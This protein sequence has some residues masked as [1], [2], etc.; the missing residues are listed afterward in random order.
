[1]IRHIIFKAVGLCNLAC[2]FC[3]YM[4]NLESDWERKFDPNR[5]DDFFAS[6]RRY[7][8]KLRVSWHGGEP[9]LAGLDFF[10]NAVDS[11]ARHGVEMRSSIQTNGV[12]MDEQWAEFFKRN[13][14]NVGVSIDGPALV[15][16][17]MRPAKSAALG[18]S[19]EGA[20]RAL[21]LL[22][23]H[24]VRHGTLT[25]IHPSLDGA[26]VFRHLVDDLGVRDMDFLLP[27]VGEAQP[28]DTVAGCR[29]YLLGVL[30]AWLA[31]DDSAIVVRYF[32][33]ILRALVGGEAKQCILNNDCSHFITV[34]P[35]GDVGLC[36]NIRVSDMALYQTGLNVHRN[37]FDEIE[38]TLRSRL[39]QCGFNDLGEICR[40]CDFVRVCQGG[41]PVGRYDGA[42]GFGRPGVY[43]DVYQS[44]IT[45][46][47]DY[48]VEQID[49]APL[50]AEAHPIARVS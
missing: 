30:G 5:L 15:Q 26:E 19:Y 31:R 7:H 22:Q 4:E 14:F 10:Q 12:L 18:T 42:G 46:I 20:V 32:T 36:E 2:P 39:D 28:P 9:L 48:V 38:R 33:N 3:Y 24:E 43:C 6:Y 8:S 1:M 11:A 37:G 17:A 45:E 35:N 25:V 23:R 16:N 41:C 40:S 50:G 44:V 29:D 34:E 27:I 13:D 47:R 21:D 49:D